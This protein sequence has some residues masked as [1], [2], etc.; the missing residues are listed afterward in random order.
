MNSEKGSNKWE[1]MFED[2]WKI[3]Q[4]FKEQVESLE[5]EKQF[6][7]GLGLGLIFGIV[8]NI[9]VSHYYGIFQGLISSQ[10]DTLFYSNLVIVVVSLVAISLLVVKW[11]K[12]K[13]RLKQKQEPHID[14][15]LKALDL[16]NK[17]RKK[18]KG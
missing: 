11:N 5:Q 9:F 16:A 3:Y 17:L 4:A 14:N 6:V 15:M 1:D 18:K 13:K 7:K 12:D 10:F 2:S 8:G